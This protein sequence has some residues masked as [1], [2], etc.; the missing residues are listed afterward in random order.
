MKPWRRTAATVVTASAVLLTG[1][2]TGTAVAPARVAQGAQQGYRAATRVAADAY[3]EQRRRILQSYR[4]SSRQAHHRLRMAL[5]EATSPEERAAAWRA[6][7]DQT[8]PMRTQ[9]HHRMQ[10]ARAAFREAVEAARS[11]FGIVSAP[12]TF[13]VV[14]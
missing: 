7:T 11:Q 9:A 6:Y 1:Q 12:S 10:Q 5:L 4:E 14:R 8:D 3:R 2:T 13:A